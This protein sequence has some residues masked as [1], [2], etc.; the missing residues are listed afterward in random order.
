MQ[1]HFK[2]LFLLFILIVG[3]QPVNAQKTPKLLVT[4]KIDG[5]QTEHIQ[6]LEKELSVGG[7]RKIMKE[8]LFFERVKHPVLSN[9]S[10]DI[11]TLLTG[12]YPNFNGIT[13]DTYF[14]TKKE[15]IR[16][17]LFD[18]KKN[19]QYYSATSLITTTL[20]DQLKL[21][22]P[23][24]KVHAIAINP[25]NAILLGGHNANSVTWIDEQKQKWTTSPYYKGGL[26]H[27]AKQMNKNQEC[28]TIINKKW[29]P[30][31]KI[32][33]YSYPTL[34]GSKTIPFSYFSTEKNRLYLHQKSL[35]N[36]PNGNKLVYQLAQRIFE[37]EGLGMDTI[38]DALMIN[39]SVF[40][41]NVTNFKLYSAE[42]EDMYLRLDEILQHLIYQ[43]ETKLGKE[44]VLFVLI[45]NTIVA[46]SVEKLQKN[47]IPADYFNV[48]R[49]MALLNSYLTAL[50]GQEKWISQ[51]FQNQIFLNHKVIKKNKIELSDIK[52]E[53]VEFLNEFEGVTATYPSEVIQ[54]Y[55]LKRD[56]II[57]IFQNSTNP[58][59]RG[60]III[61]LKNGWQ[62]VKKQEK[63]VTPNPFQSY[64]SIYFMG[65]GLKPNK[66][67]TIYKTIDIAP[68]L[69]TIL[70]ISYPN[71][72]IG[73]K[74]TLEKQ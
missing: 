7:F 45:G 18:T 38:C 26:S 58:K 1:I 64:Y 35:A 42:Q 65:N 44:N 13:G 59:H 32:V 47:N 62:I 16:P 4:I 52:K 33:N 9:P 25:Q 17:I 30:I 2:I 53:V 31:G 29:T 28:Q 56:D 67:N 66:V 43:I 69:S 20:T 72:S 49:A 3:E 6:T 27:W 71:G 21:K 15:I 73:T 11:A 57:T 54:D 41:F 63:I 48:D 40:P 24:A 61:S 37:N 68:T 19:F 34:K 70:N 55:N 23:R 12:T 22:Y 10:S 14:D 36:M 39:F 51:Y 50:Y 46:D 8:S 60:D 74:I 5:L